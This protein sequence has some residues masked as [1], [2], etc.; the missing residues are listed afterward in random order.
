MTQ[1]FA[2]PNLW[3]WSL[4]GGGSGSRAL[5]CVSLAPF[6][7]THI[8]VDSVYT[9][10]TIC[11]CMMICSR[12]LLLCQ[13]TKVKLLTQFLSVAI[14]TGPTDPSSSEWSPSISTLRSPS[15]SATSSP[16][17]QPALSVAPLG[18]GSLRAALPD[19]LQRLS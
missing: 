15:P 12:G 5:Q 18:D 11:E 19:V 10:G 13:L 9:S 17:C 14:Q 7:C 2:V 6:F 16:N 8:R 1:I 4:R 3:V